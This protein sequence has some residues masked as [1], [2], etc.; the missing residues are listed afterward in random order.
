M[1]SIEARYRANRAPARFHTFD[2]TQPP[3]LA[4]RLIARG[5]VAGEATLTMLGIAALG[6]VP[7]GVE[8]TDHPTPEWLD[9]YL[10]A[11]TESRRAV[12]RQILARVPDPRAFF[13]LRRD[14][15]L[16]STALGVVH[17]AFA[18]VE[19]V[20]TRP[21]MRGQRG[22][23][24]AVRALLIWAAS[25]GAHT[26]GLQVVENNASALAL[27]RRLGFEAVCTNQFWVAD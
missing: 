14:G 8:I 22:A 3:D 2:L 17:G 27:Y 25:W 15:R 20:A 4:D 9:V 6:L 24:A 1:S 21:D 5:Y 23:E 16:I 26:V 11:I 13:S 10:G 12:N 19:C 7:D 18:V